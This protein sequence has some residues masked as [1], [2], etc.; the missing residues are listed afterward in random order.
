MGF[1]WRDQLPMYAFQS[2]ARSAKGEAAICYPATRDVLS[3][4]WHWAEEG[5][6]SCW[7]ATWSIEDSDNV[8]A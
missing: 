5:A 3:N 2:A 1:E 4:I 8:Q 6:L 7:D